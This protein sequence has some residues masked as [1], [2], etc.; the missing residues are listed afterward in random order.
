[1]RDVVGRLPSLG[2]GGLLALAST[3]GF[4]TVSLAATATFDFGLLGGSTSY[5]VAQ[6][7]PACAHNC[8]LS[9]TAGQEEYFSAYD[10]SNNL[11]TTVGAIGYGPAV[12]GSA[13]GAYVTQKPGAFGSGETGLGESNTTPNPS[14]SDYEITIGTYLLIDNTIAQAAGYLSSSFSIE[15]IQSGEGA[16]VYGYNGATSSLNVSQ[17]GFLARVTN[18]GT[19]S[20]TQ[21]ITGLPTYYKYFVVQ[22]YNAGSSGSDVVVS[23]EVLSSAPPTIPEPASLAVLGVATAALGIVRRRRKK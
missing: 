3:L 20:D 10:G 12:S 23:R 11:L 5:P 14:D 9:G 22:G 15:S 19:G 17:L 6:N 21:T 4:S 2:R 16:T 1:M 13:P 8:V 18:P 7:A